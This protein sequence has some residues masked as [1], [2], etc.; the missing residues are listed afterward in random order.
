[1]SKLTPQQCSAN[2]ALV[3]LSVLPHQAVVG[4]SRLTVTTDGIMLHLIEQAAN[5]SFL[6]VSLERPS[7]LNTHH[8]SNHDS[9]HAHLARTYPAQRSNNNQPSSTNSRLVPPEPSPL[10]QPNIVAEVYGTRPCKTRH[11][12]REDWN[13]TCVCVVRSCGRH[14]S[15]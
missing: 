6:K 4:H 2:S 14:V 13:V 3:A 10:R 12:N 8:L 7:L 15:K 11:S 9:Q 5:N 1:L